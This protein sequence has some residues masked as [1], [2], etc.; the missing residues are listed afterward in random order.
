MIIKLIR[1]GESQ[2][3]TGAVHASQI[4][5]AYI[6]L[7]EKGQEQARNAGSLL[8]KGFINKA[9]I[10]C[11]PYKRTRQTLECILEGCG[12][13]KEHKI[14]ED[15]RLREIEFG[16]SEQDAPL[17]LRQKH[18]WFYFRHPGGARRAGATSEAS[19]II[20]K[21]TTRA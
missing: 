20:Y 11:S 12:T 16:Y 2:A 9:L 15:P 3:N 5:D 13:T 4:G 8:G 1:H 7:T 21:R 18:G 14:Y 19:I 17:K 10:Y 6:E